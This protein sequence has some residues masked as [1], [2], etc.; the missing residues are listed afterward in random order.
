M[1][2]HGHLAQLTAF[3]DFAYSPCMMENTEK[4]SFVPPWAIATLLPWLGLAIYAAMSKS[5]GDGQPQAAGLAGLLIAVMLLGIGVPYLVYRVAKRSQPAGLWTMIVVAVIGCAGQVANL[6]GLWPTGGSPAQ[7]AHSPTLDALIRNSLDPSTPSTGHFQRQLDQEIAN[8]EATLSGDEL[9]QTRAFHA[10]MAPAWRIS[11]E[12]AR[13]GRTVVERG[14]LPPLDRVDEPLSRQAREALQREWRTF[15]RGVDLSESMLE[16]LDRE[17]A[18]GVRAMTK[19]GYSEKQ[20]ERIASQISRSTAR[21]Q[22]VALAQADLA[23]WQAQRD[24]AALYWPK[25]TRGRPP[26]DENGNPLTKQEAAK[27]VAQA[28]AEVQAALR[29][30][31]ETAKN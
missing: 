18:R 16:T 29:A 24:L 12:Q 20:A 13:L 17:Q 14:L 26:K 28:D 4:R 22:R 15:K 9:I 3:P 1:M 23:R 2:A 30:L 19:A 31:A 11:A 7:V 8:L 6:A 21:Q 27:K 5:A 25:I 10:M